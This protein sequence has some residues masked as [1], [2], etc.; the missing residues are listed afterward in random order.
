MEAKVIFI[1]FLIFDP[2]LLVCEIVQALDMTIK[3]GVGGGSFISGRTNV[4]VIHHPEVVH[5]TITLGSIETFLRS[6][7]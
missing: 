6:A 2:V 3:S 4:T 7:G 5:S 1:S